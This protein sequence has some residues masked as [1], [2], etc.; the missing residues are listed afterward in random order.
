[1]AKPKTIPLS[2]RALPETVATIHK[3]AAERRIGVGAALDLL[4]KSG[5]RR[6]L[7][8]TELAAQITQLAEVGT[9]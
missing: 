3:L 4:V 1:M 9:A 5:G 7:S 2:I 6:L 8:G